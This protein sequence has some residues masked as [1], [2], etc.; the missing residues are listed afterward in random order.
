MIHQNSNF[1]FFYAKFN[2]WINFSSITPADQT[3]FRTAQTSESLICCDVN[4][5]NYKYNYKLRVRKISAHP[6]SVWSNSDVLKRLRAPAKIIIII[7]NSI[8]V[9]DCSISAGICAVCVEITF[10][11]TNVRKL[12]KISAGAKKIVRM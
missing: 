8:K 4:K 6:S 5:L 1:Y 2:I 3:L 9:F 10:V 12:L 11:C 7:V